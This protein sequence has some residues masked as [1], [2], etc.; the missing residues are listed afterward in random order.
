MEIKNAKIDFTSLGFQRGTIMSF[1]IGLD[2]AGSGQCA[3]GYRLDDAGNG[4]V[5]GLAIIMEILK[6]VGVE[7]WEDLKGQYIRVKATHDKVSAIG[8]LLEDKWLD[9]GEFAQKFR[10]E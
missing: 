6:I 1:S 3:G 4:T 2:Y 10:G 8:N 9:F 5:Y 7:N